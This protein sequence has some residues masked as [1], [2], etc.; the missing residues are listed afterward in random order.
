MYWIMLVPLSTR[1]LHLFCFF[2][3]FP[4]ARPLQCIVSFSK[5]HLIDTSYSHIWNLCLVETPPLLHT[6]TY[7]VFKARRYLKA[8]RSVLVTREG[9]KDLGTQETLRATKVSYIHGATQNVIHLAMLGL[10]LSIGCVFCSHCWN[11][12]R[13]LGWFCGWVK[14]C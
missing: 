3:L 14:S 6:C 5:R 1:A 10:Q 9:A 4:A 8:Q 2:T 12:S 11:C 7:V 13:S